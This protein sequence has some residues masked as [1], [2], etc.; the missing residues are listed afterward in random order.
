MGLQKTIL[1]WKK[2]KFEKHQDYI[3]YLDKLLYSL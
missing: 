3:K 2:M 1:T